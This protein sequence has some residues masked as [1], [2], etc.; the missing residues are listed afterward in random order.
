MD[1]IEYALRA[2]ARQLIAQGVNLEPAH[3]EWWGALLRAWPSPVE[4]L[5]LAEAA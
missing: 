1:P 3:L 4:H 2:I 5:D